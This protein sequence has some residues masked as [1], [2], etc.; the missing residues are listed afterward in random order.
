M[1]ATRV[2]WYSPCQMSAVPPESS[3]MLP[4]FLSPAE[5]MAEVGSCSVALHTPPRA[6]TN[7]AF[8][9]SMV[10]YVFAEIMGGGFKGGS[11]LSRHTWSIF[12]TNFVLSSGVSPRMSRNSSMLFNKRA[13]FSLDSSG[14]KLLLKNSWIAASELRGTT[15]LLVL[16]IARDFFRVGGGREEGGVGRPSAQNVHE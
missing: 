11:G 1:I 5:R 15:I 4:R 7:F 14:A 8:F 3:A 16:A 10:G 13:T 9:G 2:P 12:S 6:A